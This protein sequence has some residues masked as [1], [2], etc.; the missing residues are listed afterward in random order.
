MSSY[1]I[2]IIAVNCRTESVKEHSSTT[3]FLNSWEWI[4]MI[5]GPQQYR[6]YGK[7]QKNQ[8]MHTNSPKKETFSN[9]QEEGISLVQNNLPYSTTE[10]RIKHIK[11]LFIAKLQAWILLSQSIKSHKMFGV[12]TR[13]LRPGTHT[14][15]KEIVELP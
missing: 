4:I 12:G 7:L 11:N 2:K 10:C 13:S 3:H 15:M 5:S 9:S 8:E 14:Q 6:N 1:K